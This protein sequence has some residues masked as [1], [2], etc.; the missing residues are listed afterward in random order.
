MESRDNWILSLIPTV[1]EVHPYTNITPLVV[2]LLVSHIDEETRLM[3][4]KLLLEAGADP[5]DRLYLPADD[6]SPSLGVSFTLLHLC[7]CQHSAAVVRLMLHYAN[8]AVV[9]AQILELLHIAS[10]RG[11]RAMTMALINFGANTTLRSFHRMSDW[12]ASH[13]Q[14][15]VGVLGFLLSVP[16]GGPGPGTRLEYDYSDVDRRNPEGTHD[17]QRS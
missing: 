14:N 1:I 11:D 16:A 2:V 8:E 5:C 10:I 6:G 7:V 15:T 4:M 9:D 13:I 17:A 3:Q 12:Q